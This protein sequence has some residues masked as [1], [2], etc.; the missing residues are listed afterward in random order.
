MR[1][2]RNTV[3]TR[4]NYTRIT[5]APMFSTTVLLLIITVSIL[6]P[7]RTQAQIPTEL[8]SMEKAGWL[9][10]AVR[11]VALDSSTASA[12]TGAAHS[13]I[14]ESAESSHLVHGVILNSG[15]ESAAI[16]ELHAAR[17][18]A[19]ELI[20]AGVRQERCH[21][22]EHYTIDRRDLHSCIGLSPVVEVGAIDLRRTFRPILGL[23]TIDPSDQFR[24]SWR[25]A[26]FTVNFAP[27]DFID[28]ILEFGAV[29]SSSR[30]LI[31]IDASAY[32]PTDGTLLGPVEAVFVAGTEPYRR[33][34]QF[35]RCGRLRVLV[36][37]NGP[38][39]KL[40]LQLIVF[41][42]FPEELVDL[43]PCRAER[44]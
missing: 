14:A 30:T 11:I 24:R 27:H 35:T 26:G 41:A 9:R 16:A 12:S 22:P 5:D 38:R 28:A 44:K 40:A 10:L 31:A 25:P 19:R 34:Q 4:L 7:S 37:P 1:P 29:R 2:G 39:A 36:I 42:V 17:E 6:L 23:L 8:E 43:R 32:D 13:F 3:P 21:L 20:I 18:S 15:A 33:V